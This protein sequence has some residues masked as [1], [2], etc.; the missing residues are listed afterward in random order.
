VDD[1]WQEFLLDLQAYAI[2]GGASGVVLGGLFVAVPALRRRLLPLPRLRPGRWN[3]AEVLLALL[4]LPLAQVVIMSVIA[5]ISP[6]GGEGQAART[7]AT[8]LFIMSSPLWVALTLAVVTT[9]LYRISGTRPHQYGV[10]WA[11]WPA[12]VVLGSL[13][14]LVV[15][16]ISLAV[17]LGVVLVFGSETNPLE[18]VVQQGLGQSEWP[19]LVFMT[20]AAAPLTEEI[21]FRGVLQGW[22]RRATLIG[23]IAFLLVVLVYGAVPAMQYAM[24][25]VAEERDKEVLRGVVPADWTSALV[26]PILFGCLAAGYAGW[27]WWLGRRHLRGIAEVWLWR[28][29]ADLLVA[30]PPAHPDEAD[31][32]EGDA[33]EADEDQ[34]DASVALV[35]PSLQARQQQWAWANARLAVFGSAILFGLEH[36]WPNSVPLLLFGLGV[37]WLAYR[38][39]SLIGPMVCHG[40]FN[41][42]ACIVL[43]WSTL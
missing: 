8:R 4:A 11:R 41:S 21:L 18:K 5:S 7:E 34:P 32:L 14:F 38:T 40:L 43:Y 12:N 39:Q 33:V 31:A 20:V 22:L 6:P 17:Y 23:H 1:A 13:M 25:Q 28:P 19:L 15:T 16:P 29:G 3:G 35:D 9:V 30:P 36:G 37:G 2:V 27:L 26:S 42:V 10:T 24:M